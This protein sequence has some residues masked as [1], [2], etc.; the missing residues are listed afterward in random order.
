MASLR[1]R[2]AVARWAAACCE[3]PAAPYSQ[4]GVDDEK[5]GKW[6]RNLHGVGII[7]RLSKYIWVIFGGKRRV[8]DMDDLGAKKEIEDEE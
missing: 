5:L 8:G 6:G 4:A 1:H 7:L 3:A 2:S